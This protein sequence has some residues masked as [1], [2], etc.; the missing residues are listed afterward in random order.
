MNF[1]TRLRLACRVIVAAIALVALVVT[2][3]HPPAINA[4]D[5]LRAPGGTTGL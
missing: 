1:W 2:F 5:S 4:S 3:L